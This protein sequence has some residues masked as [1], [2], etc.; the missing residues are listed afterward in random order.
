MLF[1]SLMIDLG[2]SSHQYRNT[3]IG[4]NLFVGVST[5][6]GTL[7][8]KLQVIGGAYV[9]GNVGV[10]TT[11][12]TTKLDVQGGDI[13]VGLNTSQGVILTSPNGTKYRLIVGDGGGLSTVLVP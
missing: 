10:G 11:N 2:N 5:P 4:G 8:Q 7:D 3:W 1:R 6:T 13:R 9:S 12:P